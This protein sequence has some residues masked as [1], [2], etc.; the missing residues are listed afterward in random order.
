MTEICSKMSRLLRIQA[1]TD[2]SALSRTDW[3]CWTKLIKL[4]S[5]NNQITLNKLLV[6]EPTQGTLHFSEAKIESP[7]PCAQANAK[8]DFGTFSNLDEFRSAAKESGAKF[9]SVFNK[10]A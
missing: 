1:I 8:G 10:N 7:L 2:R 6:A 9:R 5:V 4:A 3:A